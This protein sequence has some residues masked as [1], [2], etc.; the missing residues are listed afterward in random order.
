[1]SQPSHPDH[2]APMARTYLFVVLVQIAV[3][4]ALWWLGRTFPR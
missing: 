3:I 2:D 1:M 4:I